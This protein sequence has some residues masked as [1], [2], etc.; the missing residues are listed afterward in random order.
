MENDGLVFRFQ[1]DEVHDLKRVFSMNEEEIT[2]HV[3]NSW[4]SCLWWCIKKSG[5]QKYLRFFLRLKLI[6][7]SSRLESESDFIC[8][9]CRKFSKYISLDD[10]FTELVEE[11]C[12]SVSSCTTFCMHMEWEY[13]RFLTCFGLS[14]ISLLKRCVFYPFFC[15]IFWYSSSL[16]SSLCMSNKV[17]FASLFFKN[18]ENEQNLAMKM[19][20]MWFV[21]DDRCFP[22]HFVPFF[23][24]NQYEFLWTLF[25]GLKIV[26]ANFHCP[27]CLCMCMMDIYSH[28]NPS[29]PAIYWLS[30][31][32]LNNN[33][34]IYD[35]SFW[36]ILS[37]S[38]WYT[39]EGDN[40]S[41][42]KQE[43]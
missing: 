11:T 2:S 1:V 28:W 23:I 39:Q 9:H 26:H 13:F 29:A 15:L 6:L 34:K 12:S 33:Q 8:K 10:G 24:Q 7:R 32:Y 18:S 25:C 36:L 40:L 20:L 31:H 16:C 3:C 5:S 42:N 41:K 27:R 19:N 38:N 43:N 17:N 4:P 37:W 30:N 35:W 14:R 21:H 22:A